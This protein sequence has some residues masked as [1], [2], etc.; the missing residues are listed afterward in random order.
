MRLCIQFIIFSLI[1]SNSLSILAQEIRN[2]EELQEQSRTEN[3]V[4]YRANSR[5]NT[6][7]LK[8]YKGL[9]EVRMAGSLDNPSTRVKIKRENVSF[10]NYLMLLEMKLYK[11]SYNLLDTDNLVGFSDTNNYNEDEKKVLIVQEHLKQIALK[12]TTDD[13]YISYFCDGGKDQCYQ[14][15]RRFSKIWGGSAKNVFSIRRT[16]KSFVNDNF[17]D[18]QKLAATVKEEVYLVTLLKFGDYDFSTNSFSFTIENLYD[19][20]IGKY[21]PIHK[22]ENLFNDEEKSIKSHKEFKKFHNK[23]K[24]NP[25]KF[26]LDM[27][28]AKAEAFL[29]KNKDRKLYGVYKIKYKRNSL[30][31][32][33]DKDAF[34]IMFHLTSPIMELYMDK[35]LS[36]KVR[37]FDI[38]KIVV[39]KETPKTSAIDSPVLFT[40]GNKV[41]YKFGRSKV[42]GTIIEI[43]IIPNKI[44]NTSKKLYLIRYATRSDGKM[45]EKWVNAV[46]L[47]KL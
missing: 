39:N 11:D 25:R 21:K 45:I 27:S 41:L 46:N 47:E 16:F 29:N 5:F 15:K 33:I 31:T 6:I 43:K 3:T 12:Q 17:N 24:V 14:W 1:I 2:N 30:G 35:D 19:F 32:S 9:P 44:N 13:A 40:V 36:E 34:P 37:D 23:N 18:L 42:G 4:I 38:S 8:E 26:S 10:G 7:K 28:P 22:Y 20:E